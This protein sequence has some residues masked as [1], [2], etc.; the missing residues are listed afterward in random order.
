MVTRR[1]LA[2]VL[3]AWSAA[4]GDFESPDTVIDMRVLGM[5]IEPPEVVVDAN[6]DEVSLADIPDIR[7]CALVADPADSR[8]L[9]YSM[10]AC[11]PQSDLRCRE[12]RAIADIV[13]AQIEDP[14]E[15]GAPVSMCG[16]LEPTGDL[17]LVV[18]ESV[19]LDDLAGFGGVGV[20]IELRVDAPGA[21]EFASKEMRF[22]P[23]VPHERVPNTNPTLDGLVGLREANGQRNRDFE[24]PIGRCADIEPFTALA[25]EKISLLPA[26]PDGVREDYVVPTFDGA[27]RGFTENLTYS[28]FATEGSWRTLRT[29]G[30]RDLAGNEPRIDG[31]WTAPRKP[32]VVGDG[33][34]VP[35]WI[36]QRDERGGLAWYE[37]CAR[38]IP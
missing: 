34:D 10:R 5:T 11:P 28:W 24:V 12:S 33:I 16:T 18:M 30:R 2:G 19:S 14:E 36:V 35:F 29:G 21:T 6:L 23:R 8:P 17:L 20:Q 4:C 32:D 25:G 37:T 27:S 13:T 26:E 3:A 38:V 7:I 15:A 22:S 31:G 9:S 1:T